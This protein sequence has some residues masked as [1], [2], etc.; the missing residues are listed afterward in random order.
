MAQVKKFVGN[1]AQF[2]APVCKTVFEPPLL[3]IAKISHQRPPQMHQAR[4]S[5]YPNTPNRI[6]PQ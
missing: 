4:Y 2:D 3:V 1:I 5:K 6:H